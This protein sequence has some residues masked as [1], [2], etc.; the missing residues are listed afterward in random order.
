MTFYGSK[1]QE[2]RPHTVID[3]M[4]PSQSIKIAFQTWGTH[5][6]LLSEVCELGISR[7]TC[8]PF[9]SFTAGIFFM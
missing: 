8:I 6:S 9:C 5:L 1:N 4:T 7:Y 3:H 2:E